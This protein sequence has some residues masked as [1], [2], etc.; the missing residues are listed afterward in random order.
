VWLT[1]GGAKI[2]FFPF[3]MKFSAKVLRQYNVFNYFS[4]K[5][6]QRKSYNA[7]KFK[8]FCWK[9]YG[10]KIALNE[11]RDFCTLKEFTNIMML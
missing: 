8:A 3:V 5:Q 4:N 9:L 2:D 11:Y 1:A 10:G 6:Q 7:S